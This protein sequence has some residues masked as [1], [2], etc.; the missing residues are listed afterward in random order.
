M[1]PIPVLRQKVCLG[2][3]E[4]LY[5]KCS[6]VLGIDLGFVHYLDIRPA[7]APHVSSELPSID[8][9]RQACPM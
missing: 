8:L 9:H 7:G 3:S 5:E 6:E 2:S 1:V 4:R